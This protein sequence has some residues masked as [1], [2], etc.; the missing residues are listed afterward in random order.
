[1]F[2]R[3]ERQALQRKKFEW[4]LLQFYLT[5]EVTQCYWQKFYSYIRLLTKKPSWFTQEKWCGW[6]WS[7]IVRWRLWCMY[8]DEKYCFADQILTCQ[9]SVVNSLQYLVP[10]SLFLS[11]WPLIRIKTIFLTNN[12]QNYFGADSV[13]LYLFGSRDNFKTWHH[14]K[15]LF[16]PFFVIKF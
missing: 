1:M 5:D 8:E 16:F 10:S 4:Y 9:S 3:Q 12:K 15:S 11:M 14:C 6:W 13:I 7:H 2:S